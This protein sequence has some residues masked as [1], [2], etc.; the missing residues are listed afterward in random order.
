MKINFENIL[1]ERETNVKKNIFLIHGNEETLG[2]R[3]KD[4]LVIKFQKLGFS[5]LNTKENPII[6]KDF[7]EAGLES[8]FDEKKIS[9][10]KNPKISNLSFFNEIDES[11]HII[12][13][14]D[15]KIKASDK[16]KKEFDYSKEFGSI[17]CY[18][19]TRESK[20]RILDNFIQKNLIKMT[21]D[22]YWF[23]LDN[24]EDLYGI[25]ENEL[26]KLEQ[27]T[28]KE[29]SVESI[30]KL[31]TEPIAKEIM[32]IFFKIN[33]KKDRLVLLANNSLN[34]Q[35]DSIYLLQR[36]KYFFDL[37]AKSKLKNERG[38]ILPKYMFGEKDDLQNIY[39]KIDLKKITDINL[40]IKRNEFLQRKLPELHKII[41][42]RFLLNIKKIIS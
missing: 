10:L 31:T 24:T 8:L 9:I 40:L 29:A 42:V 2:G 32:N 19:L 7:D 41:S 25:F 36:I 18:K 16:I 23:F 26:L 1:F 27:F 30:K 33:Q 15:Y 14:E 11:K 20:K 35:S 4:S 28:N 5:G 39:I 21:S 13:I 38:L 6:D 3:I 22:S 34:S 37:F 12:I 17:A